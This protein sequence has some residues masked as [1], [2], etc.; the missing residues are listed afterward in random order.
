MKTIAPAGLQKLLAT[1]PGLPVLDV[2]TPAEYAEAHVPQARNVP[3]R[4]TFAKGA[5]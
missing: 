2:R 4:Q 1:Q 3:A 5:V